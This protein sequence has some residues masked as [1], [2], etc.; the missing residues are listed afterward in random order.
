[1]AAKQ[2]AADGGRRP[3]RR[4]LKILTVVFTVAAV[5]SMVLV[6]ADLLVGRPAAGDLFIAFLNSLAAVAL[7]R[8]SSAG[9]RA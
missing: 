3:S 6:A 8:L 1:M 4:S 2:T 5:G 9:E 7:L